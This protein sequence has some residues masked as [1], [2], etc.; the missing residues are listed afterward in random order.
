MATNLPVVSMA[1]GGLP[2]ILTSGG[3]LFL[4][5]TEEEFVRSAGKMLEVKKVETRE[6]V[7]PLTWKHVGESIMAGIKA[8][9]L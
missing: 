3:G 2:D 1:F 6:Q 7:L 5:E 8:G 9:R 4:C